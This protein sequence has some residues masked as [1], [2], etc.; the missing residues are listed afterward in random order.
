MTPKWSRQQAGLF[1]AF[2]ENGRDVGY[3]FHRGKDVFAASGP[4]GYVVC[5][6]LGAAKAEV[7]RQ[8]RGT[9]KRSRSTSSG[10]SR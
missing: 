3:V 6:S 7:N 1:V 4:S 2:D 10:E 5:D 8:L 9:G